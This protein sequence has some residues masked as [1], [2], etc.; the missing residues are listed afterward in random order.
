[1]MD[2]LELL[3]SGGYAK[4]KLVTLEGIPQA[5]DNPKS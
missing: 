4:I 5:P 3:H 2:V 1:M